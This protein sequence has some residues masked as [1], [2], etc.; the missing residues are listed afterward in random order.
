[1]ILFG[2]L[3][4]AISS[5]LAY[6][7]SSL[8]GQLNVWISIF[9]LSA[10]VFLSA[11]LLDYDSVDF[12]NLQIGAWR[13]STSGLIEKI[14]FA[15]VTFVGLRHFL[16]LYYQVDGEF[17]SLHQFNLGDLPLHIQYIRNL[18]SGVEFP[19]IN[20]N[21]STELLRY[22]FGIDLYNALWES[23]G[24]PMSGHLFLLGIFS[25]IAA[26]VCLRLAGGW[27]A[28]AAFF[29]SGGYVAVAS[30]GPQVMQN[31]LAWKNLFLA[32]FI[33]QRGFLWALPSGVLIVYFLFLNARRKPETPIHQ[34]SL[35]VMGI[36]WSSLAFFHLHTF[37]ILS[38]MIF[39]AAIYRAAIMKMK[40]RILARQIKKTYFIW[41]WPLFI[42]SH[43]ILNS[44]N[45]LNA[46]SVLHWRLGWTI[47]PGQNIFSYLAI[48]F[49]SYSLLFV[50]IGI[51]LFRHKMK[52]LYFEFILS[53]LLF[54]LFFNLMLAPWS[55]DN[56]KILVWPYLALSMLS[57]EVVRKHWETWTQ[58]VL[59]ISLS[60]G[61]LYALSGSQFSVAEHISIYTKADIA[62]ARAAVQGLSKQA[63]FA[64]STIYNHELTALGRN[65]V[66]GYEGHL[67]G[68]GISY[69]TTKQKLLSLMLGEKDWLESAHELKANYIFWG[70]KERIEFAANATPDPVWR[71]Q[72]KNISR[73]KDYEIYEVPGVRI[74]K[75]DD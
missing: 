9:S 47:E 44:L 7:L 49:G 68:H 72:L 69:V 31:I 1:M 50:G 53:L 14:I 75:N 61:G 71:A 36:L 46:V 29:F 64:S 30:G 35:L 19:P 26:L 66:M 70:P 58:F 52:D 3:H 33:T 39:L 73:V 25:T 11:L 57:Y 34:R 38:L 10:S 41:I 37:F 17:R 16:F 8:V 45:H 20:P 23:L 32:M 67:W 18:A 5:L 6:G 59:L 15:L 42:G 13:Q 55:W 51:Y 48:N 43:F 2:L 62:K 63:I 56:I 4:I 28:M 22:P 54:L 27:I 60:Y 21:F 40:W 65:R 24:V 74:L 12:V